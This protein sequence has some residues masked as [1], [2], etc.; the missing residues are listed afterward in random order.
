MTNYTADQLALKAHLE[1]ENAAW[2]AKCEARGSTFYTTTTEDLDHW[3]RCDVYSVEDYERHALISEI[4]DAS[5]AAY[6]FRLR[7]GWDAMSLEELLITFP[8]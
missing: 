4:S 3:A 1:A 6:G 2:V 7:M 8:V 5:K